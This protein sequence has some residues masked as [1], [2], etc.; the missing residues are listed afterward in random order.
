VQTVATMVPYKVHDFYGIL[1]SKREMQEIA[2]LNI[3]LLFGNMT[4]LSL[5]LATSPSFSSI[6][7][8][9]MLVPSA[10]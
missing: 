5:K 8:T 3:Q 7:S 9:A 10:D 4:L 1:E 6:S 2:N